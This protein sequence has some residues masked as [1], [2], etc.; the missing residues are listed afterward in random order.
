MTIDFNAIVNDFAAGQAKVAPPARRYD[1]HS[2]ATD[3]TKHPPHPGASRFRYGPWRIERAD[4]NR[5]HASVDWD[6]WHEDYD[7]A[8]DANDHRCGS[9]ASLEA[10]IDE[11][12]EWEDDQ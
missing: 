10:C 2:I 9:A 5:P 11:I 4:W 8:D 6:W 1:L 12:H 3:G 7:G